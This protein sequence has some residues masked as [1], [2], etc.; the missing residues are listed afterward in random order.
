MK[1]RR[2]G[3][4]IK[5]VLI[6]LTLYCSYVRQSA[7]RAQVKSDKP[8]D[9]EWAVDRTLTVSP[10]AQPI[11]VLR[12]Q[13]Y[14]LESER[15]NGNAVPIYLRPAHSIG[16]PVRKAWEEKPAKWNNVPLDQLPV[17]EVAQFLSGYTSKTL[18]QLEFGA[19][20][21]SAEWNYAFDEGDPIGS[22]LPDAQFMR[23]YGR[24]LVLKARMEIAQGD[25]DAAAGTLRTGF[26]FS[27]H[28]A[29]GPFLINGLVAIS[30]DS[31]VTDAVLDWVGR[32]DA[33]NLYWSLTALQAP[34]IDL[35]KELDFEQRVVEMQFPD[36]ADLQR[37][38]STAE[39]EA[40]LKR[41]SGEYERITVGLI[42]G[43]PKGAVSESVSIPHTD[44]TVELAAARRYLA[45]RIKMPKAKLDA[46]SSAQMLVLYW[47]L[48]NQE[49]RDD[50]F[51]GAYLPLP[52]ALPVI[53]SARKRLESA[54]A[55]EATAIPRTLMSAIDK[56]LVAE[57][58]LDRKI[59]ALR[60]IEALRL[61]AAAHDGRLPDKL[62]EISEVPIPDDPGRGE[63][64]KYSREG[65]AATLIAPPLG[66]PYPKTGQRYRLTTK[67][68]NERLE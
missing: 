37:Q 45:E 49:L 23:I 60:V 32:G 58:R 8:S 39:W 15:V 6:A 57:N 3:N 14:P 56:A 67:T 1:G 26:A 30:I 24:L 44:R 63:P 61:Y 2:G 28:V 68:G 21:K 54:P 46:M 35:R 17:K 53:F 50:V 34:L 62:A 27:R 36:L 33:P 19:R 42:K 12:Y 10:R 38:R 48:V 55:S 51:K 41:I 13:L 25:Y 11:P 52:L 29:E 16:S 40:A 4:A 5:S 9:Q 59:A 64:F 47:G 66:A 22:L 20:R 18:K 7:A 43:D 65:E 31:Q